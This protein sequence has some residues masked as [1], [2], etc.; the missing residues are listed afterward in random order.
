[1][2]GRP[3]PMTTA[4]RFA[5]R[6]PLTRRRFLAASGALGLS[7]LLTGCGQ[8]A[9]RPEILRIRNYA[10]LTVL[11]PLMMQSQ[12]FRSWAWRCWRALVALS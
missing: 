3:H 4:E 7:S 10:D 11:D 6:E 9:H 2:L 5:I 1:M 12:W 8:R